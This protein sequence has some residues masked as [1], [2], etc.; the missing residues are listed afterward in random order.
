[1]TGAGVTAGIDLGLHLAARLASPAV[2]EEIQLRLEYDPAPP[3][4]S[5][6]PRQASPAVVD[7]ARAGLA[8]R[9]ARREAQARAAGLP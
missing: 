8:E 4:Q 5:G 6:H 1:M 9:L 7:R 2:A 3:F